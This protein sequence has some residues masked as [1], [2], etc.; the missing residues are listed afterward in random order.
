MSYYGTERVDL[1]GKNVYQSEIILDSLLRKARA[2]LYRIVVIH[3]YNYGTELRDMVRTRY[4]NH[5]K[6]IRI[7]KGSNEGETILVLRERYRTL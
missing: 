4:A 2:G 1:H 5:P 6:V 3:G 7:E